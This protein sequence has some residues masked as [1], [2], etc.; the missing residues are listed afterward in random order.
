MKRA[1]ALTGMV[2]LVALSGTTV[3][4]AGS[5]PKTRQ[6]VGTVAAVDGEAI[7]VRSRSATLTCAL[8]SGADLRQLLAAR[9]RLVCRSAQGRLVAKS[10]RQ[11]G[12]LLP[13]EL[14]AAGG[15]TEAK[16]PVVSVSSGSIAVQAGTS[17]LACQ[18]P[19]GSDLSALLGHTV[20]LHCQLVD[21]AWIV[22]KV[23]VED[24]QG[25][26]IKV[27]TAAG[28]GRAEVKGTLT[29]I[30]G[31]SLTVDSGG[32][33]F[34][35]AIPAGSDLSLFLGRTVEIECALV[36]G[37]WT[38][39]KVESK[40]EGAEIEVKVE[41]DDR[42]SPGSLS[43]EDGDDDHSESGHDESDDVYHGHGGDDD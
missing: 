31:G 2:A 17:S 23:E 14:S 1:V 26:E 43:G 32:S 39:T 5:K 29:S 25:V 3:A 30:A 7:T 41:H 40:D 34:S 28:T 35:C 21:G 9:V 12:K 10:V 36:G 33:L 16:G 42:S 18:V 11:L 38:A 20:E 6:L 4:G 19:A 8:V 27:D 22:T 24:E 15:R 37:V 13:V